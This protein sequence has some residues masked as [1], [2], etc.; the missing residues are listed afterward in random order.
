MNIHEIVE[1]IGKEMR[2][3]GGMILNADRNVLN[4]ESKE[5][6]RIT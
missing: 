1:E 3:A 2:I 6:S 5:V 4:V